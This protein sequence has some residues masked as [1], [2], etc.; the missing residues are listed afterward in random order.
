MAEMNQNKLKLEYKGSWSE[1]S[2]ICNEITDIL[3]ESPD[4]EDKNGDINDWDYWVPQKEES[5]EN[6]EK[7]TVE[8]ASFGEHNEEKPAGDSSEEI[9]ETKKKTEKALNE[10]GEKHSKSSYKSFKSAFLHMIKAIRI[11]ILNKM[12][13]LE[14]YIYRKII[15]KNNKYFDTELIN[16]NIKGV[17]NISFKNKN[18]DTYVIIISFK[19]RETKKKISKELG[20]RGFDD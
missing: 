8:H 17:S 11:F 12:N 10:A 7:R 14:K 20:E 4:I 9:K 18:E 6:I 19:D 15:V 13:K 1:I 16:A 5:K 3:E 2:E